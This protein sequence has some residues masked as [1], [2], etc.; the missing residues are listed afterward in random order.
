MKSVQGA[1]ATGKADNELNFV[2]NR[3][4]VATALGTDAIVL[5]NSVTTGLVFI[6]LANWF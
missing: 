3:D 6:N 4:P 5:A 2:G 1:V